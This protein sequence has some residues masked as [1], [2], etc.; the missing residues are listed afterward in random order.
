MQNI[1]NILNIGFRELKNSLIKNPKLDAEVLLSHV[2]NKSLKEMI[3]DNVIKPNNSEINKFK[4]LIERRKLGEPIAYIVRNKEF[5]NYNFYVDQNVLIPRPDTEV[6]L[7]QI[8]KFL[9]KNQK[10]SFRYRNW[11]RLHYNIF[12]KRVSKH[13]WCSNRYIKKGSKCSQI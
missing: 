10:I 7:E 13:L 2:L 5:W 6:I 11:V 3:I 9:D 8:F 4:A 12:S 1:H